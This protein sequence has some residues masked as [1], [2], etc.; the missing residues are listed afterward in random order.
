MLQD[1]TNVES[2]AYKFYS[3][4]SG[5]KNRRDEQKRDEKKRKAKT[6]Q[7]AEKTKNLKSTGE[8]MIKNRICSYT[9]SKEK[10]EAAELNKDEQSDE[11]ITETN[12]ENAECATDLNPYIQN[13]IMVDHLDENM[14]DTTKPLEDIHSTIL[15]HLMNA[16]K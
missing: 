8:K 14:K 3:S 7:D 16:R 15:N 1:G 13:I 10:P 4:C 12:N 11:G 9:A 5:W 6:V 2:T